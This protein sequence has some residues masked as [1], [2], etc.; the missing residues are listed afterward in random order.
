MKGQKYQN[1]RNAEFVEVV[2]VNEKFKTVDVKQA[3]G[4]V[5]TVTLATLKRWYTLVEAPEVVE[6]LMDL[7]NP[8]TE[9]EAEEAGMVT[10]D[11]ALEQ[12]VV[13]PDSMAGDGTPVTEA[14]AEEHIEEKATKQFA[15]E[16][17]SKLTAVTSHDEVP[18]IEKEIFS[19]DVAG[20]GTP[21]AEVGKEIAAQAKEKAKKAK[22][23]NAE[24]A[25]K[26][27][28]KKADEPAIDVT[29]VIDW[30]CGKVEAMGA[31]V[32]T[33][34]KAPKVRAFK[35]DGHMF[36]RLNISKKQV[37]L[38]CRS[39]A[40]ADVNIPVDKAQNH[41]FD[42]C[43]VYTDLKKKAIIAQLLEASYKY[44]VDKKAKVK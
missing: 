35:L 3:N 24:A 15:A 20:D 40:V 11:E 27:S 4:S 44:Q 43:F 5:K 2:E 8:V 22:A 36:A 7:D 19:E 25:P 10:G 18:A 33:P 28:K 16:L 42:V 41:M 12:A 1:K 31:E 34:E 14:E 13:D 30:I 32:F 17:A 6:P 9:A 26:K 39:A 37:T 21:L 38:C 29:P 23:E